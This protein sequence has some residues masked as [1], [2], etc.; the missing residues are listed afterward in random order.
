MVFAIYRRKEVAFWLFFL[1]KELG[2]LFLCPFDMPLVFSYVNNGG[3]AS[4]FIFHYPSNCFQEYGSTFS[5]IT[6]LR[7]FSWRK[8]TKSSNAHISNDIHIPI[9]PRGLEFLFLYTDLCGFNSY[10][11]N[12]RQLCLILLKTFLLFYF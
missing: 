11:R 1:R 2:T 5:I 4:Q 7:S 6:F 3:F 9:Y 10:M 12:D 8:E